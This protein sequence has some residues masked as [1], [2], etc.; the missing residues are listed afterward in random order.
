VA[1]DPMNAVRMVN[2]LEDRKTWLMWRS[3]KPTPAAP[4]YESGRDKDAENENSENAVCS[5]ASCKSIKILRRS[6][7]ISEVQEPK[8]P[9]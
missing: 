2:V 3:S 4:K 7:L 9:S 1:T 5:G 6:L 8:K